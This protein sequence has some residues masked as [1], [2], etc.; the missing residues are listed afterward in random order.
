MRL[1]ESIRPRFA[2]ERI[3]LIEDDFMLR[4]NLAELLM[5]EGY[6]VSCAADGVEALLRLVREP[7]PAAIILD[8]VLPKVNG[9]SFRQRQ[10]AVPEL[11]QIP[12]IAL[13]AMKNLGDLDHLG[14]RH[15]LPK[16]TN[17]DH[18]FEALAQLGSPS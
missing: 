16:P 9:I 11:S 10:M 1:E 8:I 7:L 14:F 4:A 12:T 2:P 5:S 18:L 13:T 15:V 6:Q 17:I 3:L